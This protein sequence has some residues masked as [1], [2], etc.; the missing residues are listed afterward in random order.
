MFKI[1]VYKY[2]VEIL[3][4]TRIKSLYPCGFR[5]DEWHMEFSLGGVW[6]NVFEF[7]LCNVAWLYKFSYREMG[8]I[9]WDD[10]FIHLIF[11]KTFWIELCV[12]WKKKKKWGLPAVST[13]ILWSS[14]CGCEDKPSASVLGWFADL[15]LV[16][17]FDFG[18]VCISV[19]D[20]LHFARIIAKL[21]L[22]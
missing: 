4:L 20:F 10:C 19:Y 22:H 21:L 14:F 6:K 13:R 7:C 9:R 3:G 12:I 16:F 15:S 18:S 5:Q 1:K 8:K 17:R 11:I 2:V